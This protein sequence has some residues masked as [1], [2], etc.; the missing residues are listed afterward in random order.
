MSGTGRK[1]RWEAGGD[2]TGRRMKTDCQHHPDE[3]LPIS[4]MT[5]MP[6]RPV[7]ARL[8]TIL[9]SGVQ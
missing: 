5:S 8:Q 6:I 4:N 3:K 7:Q 9:A 1:S 2:L